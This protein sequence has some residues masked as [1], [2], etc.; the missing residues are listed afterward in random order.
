MN[1]LDLQLTSIPYLE[2]LQRFA[3]RI[4]VTFQKEL[5][6]I[7][8]EFGSFDRDDWERGNKLCEYRKKYPKA[9]HIWITI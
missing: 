6:P 1:D 7:S 8:E 4:F 3:V 5:L 2:T 9:E